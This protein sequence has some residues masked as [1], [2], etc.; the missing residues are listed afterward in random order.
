MEQSNGLVQTMLLSRTPQVKE[1]VR[2]ALLNAKDTATSWTESISEMNT[3][4]QKTAQKRGH[5]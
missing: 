2:S 1:S 3:N 4:K 5:E